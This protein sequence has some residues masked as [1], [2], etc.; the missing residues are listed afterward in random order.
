VSD[1]ASNA[2][3]FKDK[4]LDPRKHH[5]RVGGDQGKCRFIPRKEKVKCHAVIHLQG[6]IGG[7]GDIRIRG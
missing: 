1:W 5:D 4:L 7:F 6:E 3:R 2:F